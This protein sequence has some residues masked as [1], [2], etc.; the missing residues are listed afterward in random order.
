MRKLININESWQFSKEEMAERKDISYH[1]Q[2]WVTLSLPHTW[3]AIDGANGND[4]YRGACWYRKVLSLPIEEQNN[5]IYIE[6]QGANSVTDVYLNG[7]HLGQH[8]GGYSTFRFDLTEHFAF[9]KANVLAVKVDN[10]HFDNVYPLRA[11]F[12]FFGGI[13]RDVNLLVVNPI[14]VDLLDYGSQGVYIVQEK[15]NKEQADLH[16]HVRITNELQVESKVRLCVDLFDQN[17][18]HVCYRA[19]D[20]KVD[21]REMKRVD[22]GLTIYNPKLW[23]GLKGAH[24]YEARVSLQQYNDTLDEVIV[25]FGVRYF[26]VDPNEGLFL[27]GKKVRLNGVAR[28]QDRKDMGWAI[29]HEEHDEDMELIKEVGA[30]SIRLAHYQHDQYF[31]DLCD[32]EGM[33]VWAEIPF[34]TEMSETELTGENAKLQLVELIRQN[35]NHPS[36]LFWGLQNEIQIGS[37]HEQE[38]RKVVRELNEIAKKEDP[39]RLTTMANVFMIDDEDEY[40]YMTDIIGYNKYYGWYNGKVED[41]APWLDNF[42]ETNPHISLCVSEYGAEG[43]IEYHSEEPKVKDYTEEYHALYHEKVWRIFEERPYLWATYVWNMFDFGA[44]IRDEG[45]V[46][47]RN[48]KGLVTYD[49]KVKKDAFY[50]YKAHWSDE[51][52]LHIAGKRYIERINDVIDIKIYTNCEKVTLYVNSQKVETVVGDKKIVVFQDI[53]LEEGTNHI[54]VKGVSEGEKFEDQA[55]FEKVLEPNRSY[56]APVDD[57]NERVANWFD[58]P[59]YDD[60]ELIEEVE[61][62]EGVY[63]TGDTLQELMENEETKAIVVKTLGDITKVPMYGMMKGFKVD[64]L[65]SMADENEEQDSQ[66]LFSE[67]RLKRL[68]RDLIKI[69]K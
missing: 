46:K 49:R 18:D 12:T 60:D 53:K 63:S 7:Q 34:I 43:I 37:K 51:A 17:G 59:E 45:G 33:V 39:T 66:S 57:T 2:D 6:F 29:T 14:H 35:F 10:S 54:V 58:I 1:D 69:K 32:R 26:K 56:E 44:N 36:I 22:V 48:N 38:V 16:L 68:N 23:N 21:S 27:N 20:V 13:Y 11:D 4:F 55:W 67:Q 41:F 15:V 30:T 50:M 5:R 19:A 62:P 28:H 42:H 24:M 47:G 9:G 64:I 40:N 65:A 8:R 52:S 25:P 3:N 61:I 31:Y